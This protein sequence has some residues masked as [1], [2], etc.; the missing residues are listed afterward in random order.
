MDQEHAHDHYIIPPSTFV[1]TFAVLTLLMGATIAAA[2]IPYGSDAPWTSYVA[3]AIAMTIA[4]IKS[5][6]VFLYFMGVKYTTRLTQIYAAIGFV[7]VTL[8]AIVIC[9]YATRQFEPSPGWEKVKP[10]PNTQ[11]VEPKMQNPFEPK[12]EETKAEEH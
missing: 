9:D 10:S 11:M 5:T 2:F 3:N 4:I 12:H 6:L 1:K 8:M 7:W